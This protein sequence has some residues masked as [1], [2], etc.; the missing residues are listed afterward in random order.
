MLAFVNVGPG[1]GFMFV[2]VALAAFLFVW[3]LTWI[4]YFL[5]KN[6]EP[7][8]KALWWLLPIA[9]IALIAL[10]CPPFRRAG[11]WRDTATGIPM[12]E[13]QTADYDR[14]CFGY[15]PTY[16]WIGAWGTSRSMDH[17]VRLGKPDGG[18][19]SVTSYSWEIDW[20]FVGAEVLILGVLAAPFIARASGTRRDAASDREQECSKSK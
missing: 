18:F 14:R 2:L 1:V 6:P 4:L 7:N 13:Y 8:R 15:I 17:A 3:S 9:V 10:C 20:L 12:P 5:E 11:D 19:Y 16:K